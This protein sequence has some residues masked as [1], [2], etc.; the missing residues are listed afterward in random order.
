[1]TGD[2][3]QLLAVDPWRGWVRKSQVSAR[4]ETTSVSRAITCAS[5]KPMN[6][7][8][9]FLLIAWLVVAV[10]FG[11]AEKNH[12]H[13]SHTLRELSIARHIPYF[14]IGIL[15]YRVHTRPQDR[16]GDIGLVGLCLLAI[17]VAYEPVYLE[18]AAICVAIFALFTAGFLGGLRWAPFAE[19]GA[20][21]YSLYLLHQ[22][23]GFSLIWQFERSG[24]SSS[25]AAM[26]AVDHQL[27]PA[28]GL[29][30]LV[31]RLVC[32]RRDQLH[33]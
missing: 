21:S 2:E 33:H 18:A 15:F 26:A 10:F 14:A 1:M 3:R 16:S 13:V 28:H 6:Q 30:E 19:L 11:L 7:T 32:V 23:I 25:V 31:F 9:S 22:A 20:I 17:A 5:C 4:A 27:R 12:M 24:M 29:G 8:R